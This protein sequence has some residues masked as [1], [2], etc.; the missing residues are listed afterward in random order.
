[1]SKSLSDRK[2]KLQAE[3][4]EIQKQEAE[5]QAKKEYHLS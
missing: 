1:M 3:L 5:I 2:A 4:K